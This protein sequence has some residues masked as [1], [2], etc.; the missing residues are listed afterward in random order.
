MR[1]GEEVA[2]RASVR[3]S[4]HEQNFVIYHE[5]SSAGAFDFRLGRPSFEILFA[6]QMFDCI[7]RHSNMFVRNHPVNPVSS[8]L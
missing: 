8:L 3:L 6:V 7:F 5:R 4:F 1:E 2:L